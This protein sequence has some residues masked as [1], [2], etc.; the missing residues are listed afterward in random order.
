MDLKCKSIRHSR[1]KK[2][3]GNL[4]FLIVFSKISTDS[5]VCFGVLRKDRRHTSVQVP[6]NTY[7]VAGR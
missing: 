6:Y 3:S 2:K 4:C 1:K 5:A 7:T